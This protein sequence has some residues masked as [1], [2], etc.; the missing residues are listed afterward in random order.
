MTAQSASDGTLL[1][2]CRRDWWIRDVVRLG[3]CLSLCDAEQSMEPTAAKTSGG[4]RQ[5]LSR[6]SWEN[7]VGT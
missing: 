1:S 4:I 3:I 7:Y 2:V 6:V 5:L